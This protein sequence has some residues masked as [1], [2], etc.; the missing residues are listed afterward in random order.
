LENHNLTDFQAASPK[1]KVRCPE[2]FKLFSIK[3]E[4]MVE[5]RPRFACTACSSQF[6][7]PF[8]DCL[9]QDELLGFPVS[10]LEDKNEIVSTHLRGSAPVETAPRASAEFA[11]EM[12]F[13]PASATPQTAS[14]RTQASMM[15]TLE[16]SAQ[17]ISNLGLEPRVQSQPQARSQAQALSQPPAWAGSS[18]ESCPKCGHAHA[19]KD[20]ECAHCGVIFSQYR[21]SAEDL[22]AG[23]QVPRRLR[24][25][26][27]NLINHFD[28][29]SLHESF[30]ELCRREQALDYA[31]YRYGRVHKACPEDEVSKAMLAK[32]EGLLVAAAPAAVET[33]S[34]VKKKKFRLS[35]FRFSNLIFA[36]GV[37]LMIA[38][39]FW[40]A[41]RNIVGVGAAVI[42]LGFAFRMYF[43]K[44]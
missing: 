38:G 37:G 2:C 15:F 8:P 42:F 4:S 3:V 6:W 9:A 18:A 31:A 17:P 16:T 5:S 34:P 30:I 12:D 29:A 24:D 1:V 44:N 20:E 25:S 36:L 35:N 40:P 27:K 22:K 32:I 13:A 26:W 7:I 39:Y 33:P 41:L 19:V 28:E 23:F 10:W 21:E 43:P 11:A 14:N